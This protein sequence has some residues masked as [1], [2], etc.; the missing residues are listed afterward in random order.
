MLIVFK[1]HTHIHQNTHQQTPTYTNTHT[2]TR[3]RT[4]TPT[5]LPTHTHTHTRARMLCSPIPPFHVFSCF[6]PN[7]LFQIFIFFSCNCLIPFYHSIRTDNKGFRT[8]SRK[9]SHEIANKQTGTQVRSFLFNS[10]ERRWVK[11]KEY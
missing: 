2:H 9:N 11:E 7:T 4:N 1:N 8:Y 5:H 10:L 3:A 6:L